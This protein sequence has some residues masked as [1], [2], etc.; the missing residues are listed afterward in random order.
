VEAVGCYR[1]ITIM[2]A[3]DQS[4]RL[5]TPVPMSSWMNGGIHGV[6]HGVEIAHLTVKRCVIM[7]SNVR[8]IRPDDNGDF[9][10]NRVHRALAQVIEFGEDRRGH[11]HIIGPK[12]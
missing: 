11:P 12:L 6:L 5:R 1:R 3:I 4:D 7:S 10:T 8:I 9:R 2:P